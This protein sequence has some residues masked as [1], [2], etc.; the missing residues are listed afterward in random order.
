MMRVY[1]KLK[2][3]KKDIENIQTFKLPSSKKVD[4]KLFN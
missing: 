1:V 4:S 3:S 2:I